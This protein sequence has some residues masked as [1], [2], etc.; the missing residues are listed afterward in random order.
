LEL[1][2]LFD[3]AFYCE[4]LTE[5]HLDVPGFGPVDEADL[6]RVGPLADQVKSLFQARGYGGF[7]K[8]RP[9]QAFMAR[10]DV[11]AGPGDACLDRFD[12]L[13]KRI[14]RATAG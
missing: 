5:S 8:L 10:V 14:R 3:P 12:D 9:A 2:D 11:G 13:F 4:L 6:S 1:E 7:Q